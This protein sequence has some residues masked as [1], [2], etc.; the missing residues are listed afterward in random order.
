MRWATA[1]GIPATA[2]DNNRGDFT[3]LTNPSGFPAADFCGGTV[4]SGSSDITVGGSGLNSYTADFTKGKKIKHWRDGDIISNEYFS[5]TSKL[6]TWG[7]LTAVS[8]YD[9]N[10]FTKV[11]RKG[12]A[13]AAGWPDDA[14]KEGYYRYWTGQVSFNSFGYF[15]ADN[16]YLANGSGIWF[17][18]VT[19]ATPVV[20]CVP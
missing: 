16:V 14:R 18:Y 5:T 10:F 11:K 8:A 19:Y 12:A 7:Q 20:A 2:D 1:R 15:N 4:H 17:D 6:P 9:S 3:A 13:L